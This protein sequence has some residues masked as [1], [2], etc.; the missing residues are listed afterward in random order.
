[1][2]K[3]RKDKMPQYNMGSKTIPI[4]RGSERDKERIKT[5][6]NTYQQLTKKNK[7]AG[8]TDAASQRAIKKTAEFAGVSRAESL[9]Q[10]EVTRLKKKFA[11]V[12]R[13]KAGASVKPNRKSK[14]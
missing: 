10:A 8:N 1:M 12:E 9:Y 4:T 14:K 7:K 2:P 5:K 11:D 6:Q 3:G 13:A